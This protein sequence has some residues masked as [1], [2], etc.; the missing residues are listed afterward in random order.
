MTAWQQAFFHSLDGLYAQGDLQKV[1]AF[2]LSTEKSAYASAQ[3]KTQQLLTVYNEMGSFYRGTSRY[4]KS[5][6]AFEKARDLVALTM[7]EGCEQYAT[8]LNNMAGTYRLMQKS[9]QSIAL[10]T[11]A[12]QIYRQNHL[13]ESYAYA[14]V[15]NNLALAYQENGQPA[16][17]I[18]VLGQALGLIEKMQHHKH[19]IAV[20]CSNLAT[21]HYKVGDKAQA[22]VCM[23]RALGAF[24]QCADDQNVHYAAGLNSLAGMRFAEGDFGGA[25]ALYQQS[26]A[27]T[28]RFFGE[29][30]EV[31]ITHQNMRWVYQKLGD[32]SGA[33]QSLQA[34]S[35]IY[36]NL[37]GAAH[38]KTQQV[39]AELRLLQQAHSA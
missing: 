8:I 16:L 14:S 1:E 21:L 10:F 33:M 11:Q 6:A 9:E 15:L 26:L 23:E 34:A 29:N 2:L 39:T 24:A 4:S 36:T 28:L 25:L 38:S 12:Q 13:E 22:H 35:E 30:A 18:P 3:S 37:F 27:Y 31:A 7:G 32:H 20:T 5:I 17:A 19:E